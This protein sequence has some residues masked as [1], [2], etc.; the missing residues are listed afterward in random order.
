MNIVTD[1][2]PNIDINKYA[3]S[4]DENRS[5]DKKLRFSRLRKTY[6]GYEDG[7]LVISNHII[8]DTQDE[9]SSF[10]RGICI[11]KSISDCFHTIIFEEG[12]NHIRFTISKY[13]K[14]VILPDSF[15][16]MSKIQI[17]D[18]SSI[19]D[20]RMPSSV[21]CLPSQYMG[22]YFFEN[23]PKLKKVRFPVFA[24]TGRC[25]FSEGTLL[26]NKKYNGETIIFNN[27]LYAIDSS[28]EIFFVPNDITHIFLNSIKGKIK[29]LIISPS[30][31]SVTICGNLGKEGLIIYCPNTVNKYINMM[32]SITLFDG[33]TTQLNSVLVDFFRG[34][35]YTNNIHFCSESN[36]LAK[37]D[38]EKGKKIAVLRSLFRQHYQIKSSNKLV[39]RNIVHANSINYD[40]ADILFDA[41][42][43]WI[44]WCDDK[45]DYALRLSSSSNPVPNLKAIYIDNRI[46]KIFI[47]LHEFYGGGVLTRDIELFYDGPK[48]QFLK[49]IHH[50]FSFRY[51]LV[52]CSDS[53]F[54]FADEEH[55]C[56]KTTN[57][58]VGML[59]ISG[60]KIIKT[61]KMNAISVPNCL[62]GHLEWHSEKSDETIEEMLDEIRFPDYDGKLFTY[63]F[64]QDEIIEDTIEHDFITPYYRE[65]YVYIGDFDQPFLTKKLDLTREQISLVLDDYHSFAS[66]N[67]AFKKY[68]DLEIMDY[69][70]NIRCQF[71]EPAVSNEEAVKP[72][73][74]YFLTIKNVTSIPFLLLVAL[75]KTLF[76]FD[77]CDKSF[78]S[79]IK[80]SFVF[81]NKSGVNMTI[82]DYGG[83]EEASA[84]SGFPPEVFDNDNIALKRMYYDRFSQSKDID[85]PT[86][87]ELR[88]N[89]DKPIIKKVM[90][91]L[92][93][94][95]QTIHNNE[96]LPMLQQLKEFNIHKI[97]GAILKRAKDIIDDRKLINVAITDDLVTANCVA[98]D[99]V[100]TYDLKISL[101]K[102]GNLLFSCSCPFFKEAHDFNNICKHLCALIIYVQGFKN[103]DPENEKLTAIE[104]Q[105][106]SVK[107]K[108]S[109]NLIV[110]LPD[111]I[112]KKNSSHNTSV[113]KKIER[114]SIC[115]GN[116]F[117]NVKEAE[118]FTDAES[119]I[120]DDVWE[121]GNDEEIN[122][123]LQ[124]AMNFKAEERKP[125]SISHL[126]TITDNHLLHCDTLRSAMTFAL[127]KLDDADKFDLFYKMSR[128]MIIIERNN[129][130]ISAYTEVNSGNKIVTTAERDSDRIVFS[131]TCS[132]ELSE[133]SMCNHIFALK[134]LEFNEWIKDEERASR[135][136]PV[137]PQKKVTSIIEEKV[138]AKQQPEPL[139]S[140]RVKIEE[141]KRE[142]ARAYALHKKPVSNIVFTSIAG[143][144]CFIFVYISL[145]LNFARQSN[146][147]FVAFALIFFVLLMIGVVLLVRKIKQNK[148][149]N[150]TINRC[151]REIAKLE[152][153]IG[154]QK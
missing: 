126:V 154:Q 7:V 124:Q 6:I 42:E 13:T 116:D 136:E 21:V 51:L 102:D 63:Y 147:L 17:E 62:Q 23:F 108:K 55:S 76:A 64:K 138:Q 8:D 10:R 44:D 49:V 96:K 118:I 74:V 97:D 135:S 137:C 150:A 101:D 38:D 132:K 5:I 30:T 99:L 112:N 90:V 117:A 133:H 52:H 105:K 130:K 149:H 59:E 84:F 103:I 109:V 144:L 71:L 24:S 36:I 46:K 58:S 27:C 127:N 82:Y 89:K 1:I 78:S 146:G 152:K 119:V 72:H 50:Y 3:R 91:D 56:N 141:L 57:E 35:I 134:Q 121:D 47:D 70:A 16:D 94:K 69:I 123:N 39:T 26:N 115:H 41:E 4:F 45:S 139:D 9:S 65:T 14:V 25:L 20:F 48:D 77:F 67:P 100:K 34:E 19:T 75:H 53:S 95:K 29:K 22:S 80:K 153:Q 28:E 111:I 110:N 142:R 148:I 2:K 32:E 145:I 143:A 113:S 93:K 40:H 92:T 104:Q 66:A 60:L 128:K 114:E 120:D 83:R 88:D 106:K 33:S 87:D 86:A 140:T 107:N 68:S 129:D 81:R 131:C 12:C 15:N 125:K 79:L 54:R 73:V 98:S 61:A 31:K 43:I 11:P 18:T 151:N 37:Y 85:G 122:E